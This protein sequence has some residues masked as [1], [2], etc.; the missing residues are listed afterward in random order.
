MKKLLIILNLL[1]LFPTLL[2]AQSLVAKKIFSKY[3]ND[4]IPVKIWLPKDYSKTEKYSTVY[5]FIYDHTN[6]IAATASNM[7]DVPNLIVVWA[8][9]EGG[10]EDYKSPNL[11]DKGQKYY[12]F[13]KN[14]LINYISKEYNTTNFRIAAGLSQGADYINYI[15]RNDPSLF[16]SYLV[17]STEY[18]IYY[19]PNFASYTSKIKDSL[20]YFIAIA[21]DTQERK[22]FANLLYDSL[23]TCPL[24]RIKKEYFSNASHAYSI[25]YALPDALLFTF[26]D[27]NTVRGKLPNESLVSYFINTLREKKE[28]FG[29]VDFN[30]FVY[31]IVESSDL[32]KSSVGEM[33]D[34]IDTVYSQRETMDID[35]LNIGYAFRTKGLYQN[36]EKAYQMAIL[37]KETTGKTALDDL[38]S[39]F[40]LYNV[41]DLDGKKEDALKTL[42]DGY[43]KTKDKDEG[44][45]YTIGYYYI[46]KKTDIKKGIAILKS[47]LNDKH[48]VSSHWTKPKDDVY[49]KIA[50]GYWEL[51]DKKQADIF[52]NKA[53]EINP[54]NENA[55]KLKSLMK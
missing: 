50:K 49:S 47:L 8:K 45:L 3:V 28:K 43:E 13:V 55:L 16:S 2:G 24:I 15:L 48:T 26:E 7:W 22:N 1:L 53:L 52:V 54:E 25:L 37:K 51:K 21:N 46:D 38:T 35:L 39:Y 36:A 44:L 33:N 23:K 27:Y 20:S 42:L 29:G 6:Y 32:K 30:Q 17:F 5:E 10:N 34:F 18:P 4:S 14:E 12:S 31:K 40:Q 11:T 41:Y 9:I 19:T